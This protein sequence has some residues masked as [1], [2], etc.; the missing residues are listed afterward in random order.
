MIPPQKI[1]RI[2]NTMHRPGLGPP[3]NGSVSCLRQSIKPEA[4][5]LLD[6]ELQMLVG[7]QHKFRPSIRIASRPN[8]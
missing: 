4:S 2:D 3:G 1:L 7:L 5:E 8:H 6:L